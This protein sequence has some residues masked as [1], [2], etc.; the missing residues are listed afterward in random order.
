MTQMLELSNRGF[1]TTVSNMLKALKEK[2]DNMHEHLGN[3]SREIKTVKEMLEVKNSNR[4][5]D[6]FVGRLD[7]AEKSIS[8]LEDGPKEITQTE[9]HIENSEKK[10]KNTTSKN[11]GLQD[12]RKWCN[13]CNWNTKRR[14]NILRN[15]TQG[16]SNISDRHQITVPRSRETIKQNSTKTKRPRCVILKL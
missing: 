16:F 2:V 4:N 3:V 5:E 10:K 1:K 15:N 13:M 11:C 14:R 12:H 7:T 9:T 8:E 6:Y